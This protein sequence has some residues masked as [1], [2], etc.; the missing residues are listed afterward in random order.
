MPRRKYGRLQHSFSSNDAHKCRICKLGKP[1]PVH[2]KG[3]P[4]K[5]TTGKKYKKREMTKEEFL[6]QGKTQ[7]KEEG[8]EAGK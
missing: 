4:D 5:F 8:G 1:C 3:I 6:K 7:P 2:P